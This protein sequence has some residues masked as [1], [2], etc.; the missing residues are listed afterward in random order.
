M[1]V[2]APCLDGKL[3]VWNHDGS[4][5]GTLGNGAI[6]VTGGEM[7]TAPALANLDA[8][9]QLEIV[10]GS[11]DGRSYAINHDG[12]T[13]RAGQS[14]GIFV[15]HT[16]AGGAGQITGGAIIVDIDNDGSFEIFYGR[17]NIFYGFRS[18]GTTI[19]GL[20][21]PT[22]ERI[23]ASAAAGDLDG[24]GDV[25]VAFASFDQ[26]VN[27]LDFSGAAN[28]TTLAWPMLGRNQY[29]TS[30]WGEPGPYQT[31]VNPVAGPRLEFALAQNM[32]NPFGKGTSIEYVVPEPALVSLQVF[33]VNGRLIRTLV[34]GAVERGSH[35]IQ[36][37]GRDSQGSV[38][39]SGVYFYRLENGDKTIT[40]KSVLLR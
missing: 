10:V 22:S 31:D 1:E 21:I 20:P 11:H 27:V 40:K 29:H 24:D 5:Y 38:L 2:L 26:T 34:R 32:P 33:D 3:Y 7:R 35:R 18:N 13:F 17:D 4:N 25:D 8:D 19:V 37:D 15:P 30:V 23:F 16:G 14:N 39:S 12:S 28:S 9:P 6:L 36:W